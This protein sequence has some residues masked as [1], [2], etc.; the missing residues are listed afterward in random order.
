MINELIRQYPDKT[1]GYIAMETALFIRE[2]ADQKITCADRLRILEEARDYPVIDGEN[3]GLNERITYLK[4]ECKSDQTV[5]HQINKMKFQKLYAALSVDQKTILN[6][7]PFFSSPQ[8]PEQLFAVMDMA[9]IYRENH[10]SFTVPIISSHL[11]V[12]F[13]KKLVEGRDVVQNIR[14]DVFVNFCFYKC[15]SA[16]HKEIIQ[17]A[18][19][20]KYF[21][22]IMHWVIDDCVIPVDSDFTS[23]LYVMCSKKITYWRTCD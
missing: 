12:L 13:K 19:K 23:A 3:F 8:C 11:E 4:K 22:N 17:K 2:K 20:S 1:S 7:L 15:V 14:D 21:P 16:F 5:R 18:L 9:K 6:L 10:K